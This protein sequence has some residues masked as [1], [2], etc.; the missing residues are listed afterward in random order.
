ML[1]KKISWVTGLLV[2][3]AFFVFLQLTCEYHFYYIEQ[4]QMFRYSTIYVQSKIG[5]PGGLSLLISYFLLQFFSLKFA[6]AALVALLLTLITYFTALLMQRMGAKKE[7]LIISLFPSVFLLFAHFNIYYHL[8]GTVA[9]LLMA[10]TFYVYVL[11]TNFRKRIVF[12]AITIPVLFVIGGSVFSLY[13][14]GIILWEILSKNRKW[15][16][17]VVFIFIAAVVAFVS[18]NIGI[19]SS[20]RFALL[21]DFY[22]NPLLAPPPHLLMAWI[23]FLLTLLM[24]KGFSFYKKPLSSRKN[25]IVISLQIALL[26][27]VTYK[28]YQKNFDAQTDR[29]KRLNYY[30]YTSQWDKIIELNRHEKTTNYLHL[31][32]LNSALA[33]KG[34]LAD[35]LFQFN[36]NGPYS[37][38][39]EGNVPVLLSDVYF[40]MGDIASSQRYAL[41]AYTSSEDM[42][43]PRMLQ[44][45][46]QTA[47]IYGT[48]PVAEKYISLMEQTL[49]YKKWAKE[50]RK[51][52]CNDKLVEQDSLLGPKRKGLITEP[53]LYDTKGITSDLEGIAVANPSDKTAI[54]YLGLIHLLSKDIESFGGL[55]KKYYHTDVLPGLPKSFEEALAILMVY[56]PQNYGNYRVSD[57]TQ[58][59]FADFNKTYNEKQ[60]SN[61]LSSLM[62][63]LYGKTYWYY[64]IFK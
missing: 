47:L 8:Q 4:D 52:L 14:A 16:V 38:V 59:K 42:V 51:F 49:M 5:S 26:F 60:N 57:Q 56:D 25:L 41:E 10:V 1:N 30:F 43:N 23:A 55:I 21:P 22:F 31:N 2:F 20:Y 39:V 45:L 3:A 11:F 9:Y 63:N 18:I 37:L 46:V 48:Y 58:L 53:V 40:T 12:G 7:F 17:S 44:R 15:Y 27:G 34:V 28:I 19:I 6:G 35:Q 50:H 32:L 33:E 61:D 62:Y 24:T 13:T 29:Y 36:Q 54:E 64:Y